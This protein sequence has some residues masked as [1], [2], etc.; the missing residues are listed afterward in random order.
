MTPKGL[1]HLVPNS[2]P[3]KAKQ[4]QNL[5]KAA[6]AITAEKVFAVQGASRSSALFCCRLCPGCS[7]QRGR[8]SGYG[9]GE[10][11]AAMVGVNTRN[12][13]QTQRKMQILAPHMGPDAA[14]HHMWPWW[15]A[16][17]TPSLRGLWESESQ[18]L[19]HETVGKRKYSIRGK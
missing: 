4:T 12:C 18:H 11:G 10:K 1:L 14:A 7:R 15:G 8:R 16:W 9:L 17:A 6:V 3:S 13:W 2:A 5:A 19:F